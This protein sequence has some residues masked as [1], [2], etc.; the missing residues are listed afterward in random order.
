MPSAPHTALDRSG[1]RVALVDA[2]RRVLQSLGEVLRVTGGVGVIGAVTDVVAALELV[3][4]ERPDVLVVDPRFPDLEAGLSLLTSIQLRW[5][6]TRIVMTGWHDEREQ[7][8]LGSF[9]FVSKNASPEQ[10]VAAVVN[11]CCAS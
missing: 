6:D 7:P 4:R 1:P 2:D 10:F 9:A 5:P 8:R 3:A 11:A